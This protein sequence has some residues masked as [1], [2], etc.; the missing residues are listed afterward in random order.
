[1][2]GGLVRAYHVETPSPACPLHACGLMVM[3]RA[4][5]LTP[6]PL[7]FFCL[8]LRGGA[9]PSGS[10]RSDERPHRCLGVAGRG[11]HTA[12]PSPAPRAWHRRR[13]AVWPAGRGRSRVHAALLAITS[14]GA[15][16]GACGGGCR[17]LGGD[18]THMHRRSSVAKSLRERS[19]VP[20]CAGMGGWLRRSE[21]AMREQSSG[22]HPRGCEG[23]LNYGGGRSELDPCETGQPSLSTSE[24][25]HAVQLCES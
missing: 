23:S 6:S 10:A 16:P 17:P 15:C 19:F 2:Q 14:L 5:A 9:H 1:M 4:C 18:H 24:A 3:L 13:H 12:H 20:M 22:A 11:P 25:C 21:F 7:G 8:S